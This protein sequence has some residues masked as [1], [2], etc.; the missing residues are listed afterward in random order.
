MCVCALFFEGT[1]LLYY[2]VVSKGKRMIFWASKKD[3]LS[4]W[5]FRLEIVLVFFGRLPL[6]KDNKQD[7]Q[8]PA[9]QSTPQTTPTRE[10]IPVPGSILRV[11]LRETF[12]A[13][14]P[15]ARRQF[16]RSSAGAAAWEAWST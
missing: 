10:V 11:G 16:F 4:F 2:W 13:A 8:L 6:Q 15:K 1:T 3:I 12:G 9:L 14:R 7:D 5:W